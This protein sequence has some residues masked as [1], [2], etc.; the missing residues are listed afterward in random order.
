MLASKRWMAPCLIA[1][2]GL[3][4]ASCAETE[5]V[6][7]T[8]KE[9]THASAPASK[10]S[11]VYKVGKPYQVDGVWYYPGTDYS[12]VATGIA[13]WYGPDF[14]GK[15]T[16]NGEVFDMNE[17]TGAHK[18]LPLPTIA[19][20]TNLENGRSIMVR[21]N[22]RGPFANGRII[23]LSRRAAQLLGFE[24]AGTAKVRV[25]VEA[26]QSRQLA[27]SLP[28]DPSEAEPA[29]AVVA[30]P[31]ATVEAQA[32]PPPGQSAAVQPDPPP[33]TPPLAAP[34]PAA[35][36]QAA[37]DPPPAAVKAPSPVVTQG[38][39]GPTNV[40]IQAGAFSQFDNANRLRA[41]LS[42][43]GDVKISPVLVNNQQMFRV[44]L[45]P[46]SNVGAADQ[47]LDRVI[48]AGYKNA[49]LIVAE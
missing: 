41:Q 37:A 6:A 46:L 11:P 5:I 19:R 23:D 48:K 25:E 2:S 21:I 40:Y 12:Y 24:Q 9:I 43:L 18:T 3:M 28:R 15:M 31:R 45:G 30:A 29:P 20:V 49:E 47:L 38:A 27:L 14:H 10:S 13:S 22:D 1:A 32:L 39:P 35:I 8:T 17:V 4:L 33:A 16:A 26:D 7:N 34:K 36:V 42:P 44:R